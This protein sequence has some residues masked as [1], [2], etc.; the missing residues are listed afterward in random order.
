M[1]TG[2][3]YFVKLYRVHKKE[4]ILLSLKDRVRMLE[5]A[6]LSA[7]HAVFFESTQSDVMRDVSY[8][9]GKSEQ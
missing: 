8:S 2:I 3:P 1:I 7:G 6:V 4:N 5:E 9:G